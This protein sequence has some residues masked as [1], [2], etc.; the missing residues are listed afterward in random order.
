MIEEIRGEF[1]VLKKD[2]NYLRHYMRDILPEQKRLQENM[3]GIEEEIKCLKPT[4]PENNIQ[5]YSQSTANNSKDDCQFEVSDSTEVNFQKFSVENYLHNSEF[6]LPLFYENLVNPVLHLKQLDNYIKLKKIPNEG[7]L[8]LAY[9]SINGEMSKQWIETI[10]N[11]IKDYEN[12]KQ[13]L[14][15]TWWSTSQQSL[16]KCSLCQDKYS[17]QL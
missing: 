4:L 9:R 6:P 2:N 8:I 15:N 14:L 17:K 13:E 16:V 3:K 12:F 10:I 1:K 11:R 7:K 5:H